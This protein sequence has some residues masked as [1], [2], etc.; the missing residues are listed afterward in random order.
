MAG[1]IVTVPSTPESRARVATHERP[2]AQGHPERATAEELAQY[3]R[4]GYFARTGVFDARELAPL[5]EAVDGIHDQVEA[6]ARAPGV[7]AARLIDGRRYQQILGS[8][9]QWEWRDESDE[10]RTMEP[11]H[12]LD[13]RMDALIDDVRLW[14]PA[15]GVVRSEEI[16]LFSDKLNFKRPG[17]APF[18]WHQDNPYWAFL[19]QHLDQLV[20]VAVIL[21]DST[22][23]NG[24]LWLI[25]ESH[26]H[27]ALDCFEDRGVVGR[28][29]TD[30]DRYELEAPKPMDLPAG[31]IVYF[32]GDVVHGSM[33]NRS[34]VRRRLLLLTYQPAGHVRW[35]RD[36]VRP[37]P[38]PGRRR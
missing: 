15:R 5:R 28:L 4:E 24:C 20:S 38:A 9:V 27:G 19:C 8:S 32:H 11:Y 29:Y 36:D 37:V 1:E 35:Q 13:A 21:D 18:P 12:H 22:I 16:S 3:E 30:I 14:G 17:G 7:E 31:S 23:E 33:S 6:A 10:I 34:D 25:P 2:R 26:K